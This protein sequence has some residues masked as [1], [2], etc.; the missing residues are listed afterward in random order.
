M[1]NIPRCWP[2]LY[3]LYKMKRIRGH[4][5]LQKYIYLA[6]VEGEVPIEYEFSKDDYGPYSLGIKTD[7]FRL[8]HEGYIE[9]SDSGGIWV[10][11]I[12][13]K[14]RAVIKKIMEII[15]ESNITRF[16]GI[17]DKFKGYSFTKLKN[18]VYS[19]HVKEDLENNQ[20]KK[21]ILMDIDDLISIFRGRESSHNSMFIRGSL[22][23]CSMLLKKEDLKDTIKKDMLLSYISSYNHYIME[24]NEL[25][26]KNDILDH[27]NLEDAVER[28]DHIQEIG[29]K[30]LSIMPRLDDESADLELFL[31]DEDES[32]PLFTSPV[33]C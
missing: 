13:Q 31:D 28:F 10:F 27:L 1:N 25:T 7:A 3:T 22:D 20:L 8:D 5:Y 32:R 33:R 4:F 6:K 19:R 9:L 18:Y 29:S 2:I 21:Q 11:Q 26:V 15:P 24:L 14:G 16:D 23:Y 12:T 17:L 30:E